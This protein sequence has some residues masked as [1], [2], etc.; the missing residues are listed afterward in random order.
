MLQQIRKL[1]LEVLD[2]WQ[3]V[4]N[5]VRLIG[6]VIEVVLMVILG[7]VEALERHDLRHDGARENFRLV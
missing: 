1:L 3:I 2:F 6:V 5:Y 4:I 7:I